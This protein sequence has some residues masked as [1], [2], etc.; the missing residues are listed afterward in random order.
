MR[1][2]STIAHVLLLNIDTLQLKRTRISGQ[3][4]I[5]ITSKYLTRLELK[6]ENDSLLYYS[7]D[8]SYENYATYANNQ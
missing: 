1:H 4:F 3:Y 5:A 8:K 2:N 6:A 7:L